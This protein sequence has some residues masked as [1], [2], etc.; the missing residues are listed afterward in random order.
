MM[1]YQQLQSC[2]CKEEL[3]HFGLELCHCVKRV[4]SQ[5]I[6]GNLIQKP[7]KL[8]IIIAGTQEHELQYI[9]VIICLFV[10]YICSQ[11]LAQ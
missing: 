2:L 9:Y 7:N 4:E 5:T 6:I 10:I 3:Q 11:L 8:P 1:Q